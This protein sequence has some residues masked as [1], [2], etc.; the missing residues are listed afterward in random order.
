MGAPQIIWIILVG[1]SL[2]LHL[3]NNGKQQESKY[4]FWGRAFG[5]MILASLLWW[6]G[7]F[8]SQTCAAEVPANALRHR[9][10]LV[11]TAQ[12]EWGLNAPVATFA[13]QIHQESTWRESITALDDG[14]GLAQFMDSTAGWLVKRYPALGKADP[15]NP[16]WS[17]RALVRYDRHLFGQV[18]GATD[19]ERM[20]AALKSYNAGLGYVLRAQEVSERPTVWFGVTEHIKTGQSA[21]NFEYSRLYPHKIIYRHQ[22]HYAAAGFGKGVCA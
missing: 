8:G 13:A 21:K 14:R 22:P 18:Q 3:A 6:G 17:M 16:A 20:G 5:S 10:T 19:C 2:G 11:R 15:Y 12:A 4:S 7:F 1:M 9:A